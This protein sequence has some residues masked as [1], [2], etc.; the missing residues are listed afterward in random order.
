MLI[1]TWMFW[2]GRREFVHIPPGGKAFIKEALGPKGIK[3][4]K[5]LVPI[6]LLISVFWSL[7]DQNAS[8]WVIQAKEMDL[9]FMGR[10]WLPSQ[11]QAINPLLVMVYIPLFTYLLY[12]TISR[13]FPLNAVR[14]MGIGFFIMV[15]SFLI[16]AFVQAGIE[17]GQTPSI[18]W[19]LIAFLFLTAAEVMIYQTGLELTYTQA[20]NTMKSFLMSLFLLTIALGNYVTSAINFFIKNADGT[21]KLEGVSYFLFFSGLMIVAAIAFVFVSK[22]FKEASYIQGT[23]DTETT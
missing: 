18:A 10:E 23:P 4:L 2:L 13:F 16:I 22:R 14:K 20:P 21:S 8:T 7:Y 15:P 5:N 17:A 11:I 19:H 9:Q 12:H 3:S 6:Y 1:A